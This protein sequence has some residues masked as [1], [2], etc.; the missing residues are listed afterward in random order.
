[1]KP[2]GDLALGQTIEIG[3]LDGL[4]LF[5][6]EIQHRFLQ[7]AVA[8]AGDDKI[9]RVLVELRLQRLGLLL[10]VSLSRERRCF[11]RMRSMARLRAIV[12]IQV[13]GLPFVGS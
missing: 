13:S 8:F 10:K 9:A 3:E 11:E 1:M 6:R 12:E 2:L 7:G 4:A 5:G